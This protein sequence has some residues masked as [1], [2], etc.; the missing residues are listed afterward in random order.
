MGSVFQKLA[1]AHRGQYTQKTYT[2]TYS[3]LREQMAGNVPQEVM[4]S[5]HTRTAGSATGCVEVCGSVLQCVFECCSRLNVLGAAPAVQ[6][7]GGLDVCRKACLCVYMCA[8][9]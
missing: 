7:E 9:I 3:D 4:V 6:Q 2:H 5:P 1:L 8:C